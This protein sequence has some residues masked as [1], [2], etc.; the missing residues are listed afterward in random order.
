MSRPTKET[1]S[2]KCI[3]TNDEKLEY[4]I[5]ISEAFESKKCKE[6]ELNRVSAQIKGEIALCDAQIRVIAQKFTSGTEYREVECEIL[7]NFVM[8]MRQW[9][10]KDTG[11]I[12]KED[13][14][15]EHMLQE[16][17]KLSAND[18]A[19]EIVKSAE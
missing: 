5:A 13:I 14:I 4:G 3:L 6:D 9:I 18:A 16:E 7:Y 10:R 1:L 15:P 12:Y 17:M 2:V 19:I 8:R 11:E